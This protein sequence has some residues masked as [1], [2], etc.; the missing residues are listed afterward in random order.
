MRRT[1]LEFPPEPPMGGPLLPGVDRGVLVNPQRAVVAEDTR[2]V[3]VSADVLWDEIVNFLGLSNKAKDELGYLDP[4]AMYLLGVY[5]GL[6][7]ATGD[8]DTGTSTKIELDNMLKGAKTRLLYANAG[9]PLHDANGFS[10]VS[11]YSGR[12][13]AALFAGGETQGAIPTEV[14]PVS[15]YLG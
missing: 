3:P 4:L 6:I 5:G 11:Y 9:H 13:E 15:K 14:P 7:D 8:T 2:P 12:I 1:G 10:N